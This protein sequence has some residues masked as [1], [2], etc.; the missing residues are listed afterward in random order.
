MW[1]LPRSCI[2]FFDKSERN[3]FVFKCLPLTPW[4]QIFTSFPQPKL[5][6]T[7]Y[8]GLGGTPSPEDKE[9]GTPQRASLEENSLLRLLLRHHIHGRAIGE[10]FG[11]ALHHF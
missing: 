1:G 10:H 6:K 4:A 8:R 11:Y 2:L 5:L 3:S 7:K 9:K